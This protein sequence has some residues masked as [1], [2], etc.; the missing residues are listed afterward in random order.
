MKS[1]ASLSDRS[2]SAP[3]H[4]RGHSRVEVDL[5]ALPCLATQSDGHCVCTE[6]ILE[7]SNGYGVDLATQRKDK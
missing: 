7:I 6:C 1:A 4:L 3:S 2:R 5:E